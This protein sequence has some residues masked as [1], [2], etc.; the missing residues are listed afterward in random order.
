MKKYIKCNIIS[1]PKCNVVCNAKRNICKHMQLQTLAFG[2]F[3][4]LVVSDC[5]FANKIRSNNFVNYF[6]KKRK[7]YKKIP[8]LGI[9]EKKIINF[10]QLKLL[11]NNFFLARKLLHSI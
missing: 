9:Y 6:L 11:H 8:I 7:F 2:W 10:I 4:W 3:D 1:N 5:I